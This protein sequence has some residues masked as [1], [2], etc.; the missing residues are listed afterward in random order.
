MGFNLNELRLHCIRMA[1]EKER[2]NCHFILDLTRKEERK[3]YLL[4][5]SL[6]IV[7][8]RR[9]VFSG[10]SV[11]KRERERVLLFVCENNNAKKHEIKIYVGRASAQT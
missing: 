9:S 8:R 5:K 3:N 6:L 2:E 1:K 10:E 4:F 11:L 7:A